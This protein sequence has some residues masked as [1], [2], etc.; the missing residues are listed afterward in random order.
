MKGPNLQIPLSNVLPD[1]L[2][3]SSISHGNRD[4]IASSCD[5]GS[6]L[7]TIPPIMMNSSSFSRKLSAAAA[8]KWVTPVSTSEQLDAVSDNE[9]IGEYSPLRRRMSL[10]GNSEKHNSPPPRSCDKLCLERNPSPLTERRRLVP[11][12]SHYKD[13]L[14]NYGGLLAHSAGILLFILQSLIRTSSV[15][16]MK[17]SVIT[18]VVTIAQ[19]L[20]DVMKGMFS[21]IIN[22]SRAGITTKIGIKI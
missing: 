7:S 22:G 4:P 2:T 13:R 19:I 8:I 16:V 3:P 5:I 10:V 17:H 1:A 20:N 15:K 9:G 21:I 12:F 18:I 14:Q 6:T 11:S